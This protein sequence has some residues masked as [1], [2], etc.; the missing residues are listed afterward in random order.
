MLTVGWCFSGGELGSD[1]G[2]QNDNPKNISIVYPNSPFRSFSLEELY[3]QCTAAS[4]GAVPPLPVG[5]GT[6]PQPN[7]PIACGVLFTGTKKAGGKVSQVCRFTGGVD[8][9]RCAFDQV[10]GWGNVTSVDVSI[11]NALG[12]KQL[13]A[14]AVAKI[15]DLK[16]TNYA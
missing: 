2:I 16:H 12:F 1:L 3:L 7:D 4:T 15:D 10:V 5:V 14:L 6:L 13:K 11:D 9:Q 8:L